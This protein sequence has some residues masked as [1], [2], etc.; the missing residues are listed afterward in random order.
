MKI[1]TYFFSLVI[2]ISFSCTNNSSSANDA[3][4]AFAKIDKKN[5]S[6]F[7]KEERK[8]NYKESIAAAEEN[9]KPIDQ[10]VIYNGYGYNSSSKSKSKTEIKKKKTSSKKKYKTSAPI[11]YSAY[12]TN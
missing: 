4:N 6:L 7:T 12:S 1:K 9:Q 8:R 5:E 3:E 11:T 10:K 2:A